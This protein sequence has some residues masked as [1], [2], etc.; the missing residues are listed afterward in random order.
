MSVTDTAPSREAEPGLTADVLITRAK[1]FVPDLIER[2]AETE[3]RTRYAPDTH[4]AFLRAGFYRAL[5]PRR[6]G[7]HEV[8]PGTFATVIK[9]LAR[10]CPSTAWCVCL[11]AHHAVQVATWFPE[12]VQAEAFG[13]GDFLC[14][15]VSAPTGTVTRVDGGW[16]VD[17]THGY[18]SGA[19]YAT[20]YL[21][22]ALPSAEPN[23][24]PL[25]APALFLAPRSAWA[26]LDDWGTSLGLKG[27]G[28][29]SLRFDGAVLP[30]DY[31]I[32][33]LFLIDADV[34]GGTEGYRVHRN[35]LYAGRT[36]SLFSLDFAALVV[37]MALG[38]LEEYE[39]IIQAKKTSRP[40][41]VLRMH[42]AHYQRW[43]GK[44]T[45]KLRAAEALVAEAADQYLDAC[46]V[47]VSG[48][49]P[50]TRQVDLE[51]QV[52]GRESM[53]L[54]WEAMQETLFRTAG[55]AAAEDGQRMQRIW[56]D[57]SMAWGHRFNVLV[58]FID[59]DMGRGR[60]GI[61]HA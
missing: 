10:G 47:G 9:E 44:A 13:D 39:A 38:A 5:V 23:G 40:P 55:S 45:A 21:G 14:P 54:S 24:V 1:A 22:Q 4:E 11:A 18:A 3:K 49:R 27:S 37:G 28:S 32:E 41:V 33:S 34:T 46:R 15:S 51:I 52:L 20:H 56:R 31:V 58:E 19:P 42:N 26:M 50:F 8:D 36:L 6:Y 17:G 16:R 48:E 43:L 60:L 29:N 57:M 61:P 7:G 30:E 35:P 25:G 59:E 2:Q 12:R 53:W